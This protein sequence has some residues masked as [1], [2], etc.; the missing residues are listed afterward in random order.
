MGQ[1]LYNL[2]GI[3]IYGTDIAPDFQ[4]DD[5][6]LSINVP[7]YVENGKNIYASDD[8]KNISA[9][10]KEYYTSMAKLRLELI[11]VIPEMAGNFYDAVQLSSDF[12][13]SIKN[14]GMNPT[15]FAK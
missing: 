7:Y 9:E 2:F 14:A 15:K 3:N 11:D 6:L 4:N 12:I 8:L 13:N 5:S 1:D 10:Q